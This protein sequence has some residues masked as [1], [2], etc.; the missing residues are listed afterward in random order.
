MTWRR[1]ALVA[2]VAG[3]APNVS[4]ERELAPVFALLV[5][6]IAW[7]LFLELTGRLK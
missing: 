5:L 4:L 7:W 2:S 3:T 6:V 1:E